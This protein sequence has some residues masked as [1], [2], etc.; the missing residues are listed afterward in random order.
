MKITTNQ[1]HPSE[2]IF[3]LICE[4]CVLKH[5]ISLWQVIYLCDERVV[6]QQISDKAYRTQ[7]QP[8]QS[9]HESQGIQHKKQHGQH[10]VQ[11]VKKHKGP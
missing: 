1:L 3:I 8:Y 11:L 6:R 2:W 5:W 4:I 9:L 10:M 7:S